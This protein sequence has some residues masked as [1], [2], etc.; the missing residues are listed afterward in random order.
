MS[1]GYVFEKLYSALEYAVGTSDSP[2]ERLA[3]AYS[4]GVYLLQHE[5]VADEKLRQRLRKLDKALTTKHDAV[6]GSFYAS[7][8]AMSDEE[9]AKWLKEMLSILVEVAELDRSEGNRVGRHIGPAG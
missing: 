3:R 9:A 1:Y 4:S 7:A 2:Q 6:N 8:S 5:T